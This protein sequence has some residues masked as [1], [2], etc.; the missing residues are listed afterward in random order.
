MS[1]SSTISLHTAWNPRPCDTISLAVSIAEAC[2]LFESLE[3]VE[4]SMAPNV[5][6]DCVMVVARVKIRGIEG[7]VSKGAKITS[8]MLKNAADRQAA[9]CGAGR[10][11]GASCERAARSRMESNQ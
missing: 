1:D 9:M 8:A 2:P 3:A 6:S 10:I 11:I 7:F 4:F 5:S